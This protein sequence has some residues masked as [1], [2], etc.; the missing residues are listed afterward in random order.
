LT[1]ACRCDWCLLDFNLPVGGGIY[2]VDTSGCVSASATIAPIPSSILASMSTW[3]ISF[4]GFLATAFSSR[5]SGS[6]SAST[7][8][9]TQSATGSVSSAWTSTYT[10]AGGALP[11]STTS[12]GP[13]ATGSTPATGS[14]SSGAESRKTMSSIAVI[15]WILLLGVSFLY[16]TLL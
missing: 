12:R 14:N 11:T 1:L 6:N 15:V 13:D 16:V 8:Q 4:S 9:V 5:A 3:N 10:L 2:T 7:G